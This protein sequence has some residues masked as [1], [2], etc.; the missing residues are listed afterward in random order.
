MSRALWPVALS[1]L[2]LLAGCADGVDALD[3]S[4]ADGDGLTA[5]EELALGT[6]PDRADTDGDGYSDPDELAFGSDPTDP[7][8]RIYQGGW[9]WRADKDQLDQGAW[10]ERP[11][12]GE[13]VPWLTAVD[14][15]GDDV[16]LGDFAGEGPVVVDLSTEWCGICREMS[17]WLVGPGDRTWDGQ[18]PGVREAVQDGGV[19]W[20]TVLSQDHEGRPSDWATSARWDAELGHERIPV[21]ADPRGRYT[22]WSKSFGY[23]TLILLDA[24]LRLVHLESGYAGTLQELSER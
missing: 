18:Y 7:D 5:T 24:D 16:V 20:I 10:D 17:T 3:L 8:D 12:E 1:V 15:F 4:D 6:D 11:R 22:D 9:P 23:P 19:R 21:L 2:G 13:A 14:Q